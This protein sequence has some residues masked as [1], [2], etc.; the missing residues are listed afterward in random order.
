MS[1]HV[2]TKHIS[3]YDYL[4]H[5]PFLVVTFYHQ[6]TDGARTERKGWANPSTLHTVQH[7]AVVTRISSALLRSAT[8]I[9]DILRDQ[10]IKNR[11]R[12]NAIAFDDEVLARYTTEYAT[13]IADA[14]QRYA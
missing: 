8:V 1:K 2:S 10:V 12:D 5:R 3:K 7:P 11:L 13:M 4:R 14:K 9:I 6:P